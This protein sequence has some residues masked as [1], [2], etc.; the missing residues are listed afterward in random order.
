VKKCSESARKIVKATEQITK[1]LGYKVRRN[2][3]DYALS[4]WFLTYQNHIGGPDQIQVEIN[5]LKR[6]SALVLQLRQAVP[7]GDEPVCEFPVLAI[8]ELLAGKLKAMIDRKHPRDLC[9]QIS[10]YQDVPNAPC[11][12]KIYRFSCIAKLV[13]ASLNH[14]MDFRGGFPAS[15]CNVHSPG[16]SRPSLNKARGPHAA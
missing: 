11:S 8:E 1:A 4:E 14:A 9:G 2:A 6:A 7:M 5:F 10:C 13:T 16:R 3:D 15:P 12:F